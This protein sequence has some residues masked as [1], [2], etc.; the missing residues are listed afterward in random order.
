MHFFQWKPSLESKI[1]LGFEETIKLPIDPGV[2]FFNKLANNAVIAEDS[3]VLD[4]HLASFLEEKAMGTIRNFAC[5][6]HGVII[7]KLGW[8]KN[9]QQKK[10]KLIML[11]ELLDDPINF[12]ILLN[13][14]LARILA[15]SGFIGFWGECSEQA[16]WVMPSAQSQ[17]QATWINWKQASF[18]D[19]SGELR[20]MKKNFSFMREEK[21]LLGNN[22]QRMGV[23]ELYSFLL[24]HC[25]YVNEHALI[26][27][28]QNFPGIKESFGALSNKEQL[29]QNM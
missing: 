14:Y 20:P 26:L 3:K 16:I 8:L 1:Y 22:R 27:L 9:A 18:I 4:I 5:D 17:G 13:H 6:A 21:V 15:S 23:E 7:P 12:S 28:A 24:H 11:S 19:S 10:A 25:L 29:R 2:F